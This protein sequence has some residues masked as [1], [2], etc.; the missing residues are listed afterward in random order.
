MLLPSLTDLTDLNISDRVGISNNALPA[1]IRNLASPIR[2]L[3]IPDLDLDVDLDREPEEP[4]LGHDWFRYQPT[5]HSRSAAERLA[6]TTHNETS[7]ASSWSSEDDADFQFQDYQDHY[8]DSDNTLASADDDDDDN[9][10]LLQGHQT[11]STDDTNNGAAQSNDD[12]DD[13]DDDDDDDTDPRAG[14]M[15]RIQLAQRLLLSSARQNHT[16][17]NTLIISPEPEEDFSGGV[18]LRRQNAIRV[19]HHEHSAPRN[20]ATSAASYYNDFN[21][22]IQAIKSL[23]TYVGKSPL[24][25][26]HSVPLNQKRKNN[27]QR[28]GCLRHLSKRPSL[29]SKMDRFLHLRRSSKLW[30]NSHRE[31]YHEAP[32]AVQ[33]EVKDLK[34]KREENYARNQKRRKLRKTS[35][36][37]IID[38]SFLR[39]DSIDS[40]KLPQ[41]DK[42]KILNNL[43]C[44]YFRSGSTF[45]LDYVIPPLHDRAECHFD[46]NI[47]H[48]DH[49]DKSFH[50]S[51]DMNTRSS[52]GNDIKSFQSFLS[53][54][55]GILHSCAFTNNSNR[56]IE[57]K[58]RLLNKLL[59][60]ISG[61]EKFHLTVN[62]FKIPIYGDIIDFNKHDLRFLPNARH[63]SQKPSF[64]R[65]MHYSRVRNELIKMQLLEW[66]RIRPFK[67]F[68]DTFFLNYIA[69][70][71]QNLSHFEQLPFHEQELSLEFTRHLKESVFDIV[72]TSDFVEADVPMIQDK[73]QERLRKKSDRYEALSKADGQKSSFLT[74]WE[75]KLCEKLCECLT[76]EDSCLLN[77][78]LNYVLFTARIDISET[79]DMCLKRY[80]ELDVD[81]T[82]RTYIQRKLDEINREPHSPDKKE[83][84]LLGSVN[85][86]T[87][88]L[89]LHNTRLS[90]DYRNAGSC[91]R[92]VSYNRLYGHIFDE[93]GT[94][95]DQ[96]S[97]LED[98]CSSEN[99]PVFAG[100]WK[101]LKG[102]G[103]PLYSF[104]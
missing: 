47:S 28:W 84:V 45:S 12:P 73:F 5:F 15:D 27:L 81:V 94:D 90:L 52:I 65:S 72:K 42:Y 92:R 96:C 93:G 67:N 10:T 29:E 95:L 74:E 41:A 6:D 50:G 97:S 62:S 1:Q 58:M 63:E 86:K 80:L 31:H 33:K 100:S 40:S 21:Q 66:M 78:Q 82:H 89:E 43:R 68:S 17:R 103:N 55:A 39:G 19:K 104:V 11:D 37:L 77:V 48:I 32:P 2:F 35:N 71:K 76:C 59:D 24:F 53:K 18:P 61:H 34:R 51:F 9:Q 69:F 22:L 14:I 101:R 46:F 83:A 57:Y 30:S 75:S 60:S 98:A 38:K 13:S 91:D 56:V 7:S 49:A 54:L 36:N 23:P 20:L 8:D 3:A 26:S 16:N 25:R 102:G 70:A 85:R 44:S 88:Q 64:T 99:P 79:L 87:G 4:Q